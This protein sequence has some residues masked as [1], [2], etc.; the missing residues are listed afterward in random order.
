M[1]RNNVLKHHNGVTVAWGTDV[2]FS[3]DNAK[4]EGQTHAK[5]VRW[6]APA[7]VLKI[8]TAGNAE[9]LAL[10]GPRDP[11]PDR[12]GVVQEGALADRRLADGDPIANDNLIEDPARTF[13]V[14]MKDGKVYW[15]SPK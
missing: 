7:E 11:Y 4:G 6:F 5:M 2:T 14:I 1:D 13:V 12:V 10:A 8:A 15:N 9:L 3:A